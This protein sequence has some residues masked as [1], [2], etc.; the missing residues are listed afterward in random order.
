V[1]RATDMT[2]TARQPELTVT[3][4]IDAPRTLVFKAWTQ[5][6]HAARWWGPQGFTT[7]FCEM[8]VRP[9]GRYRSS[10]RSPA[11]SIHTRRGVY[12]NVTYP[13]R[14]VFTFAW[15]DE[16]GQPTHETLVTVTFEDLDTRTRLTL[17]QAFF[18]STT[19]RDAHTTGWTSCLER[20]AE[21]MTANAVS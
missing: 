17:H 2:T 13:E 6:E 21:Y 14:L 16:A 8:D 7:I 20:F 11:G 15:E 18:E 1:A 9:G 12:R 3:R 4:V 19:K 10:M 5:Q